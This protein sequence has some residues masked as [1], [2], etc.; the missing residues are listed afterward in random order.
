MKV[1]D[2]VRYV[3]TSRMFEGQSGGGA[4]TYLGPHKTQKDWA[5]VEWDNGHK[6]AYPNY[7]LEVI[8]APKYILPDPDFSLEEIE[9]ACSLL[10]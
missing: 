5:N 6:N 3:G 1:G 4:G 10:S 8:A 9:V 7:D 2:K